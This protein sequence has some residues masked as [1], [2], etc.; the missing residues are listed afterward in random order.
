MPISPF[1]ADLIGFAGSFCIVAAFAYSNLS[2]NMNMILF[3][4]VNLTGAL[5]LIISLTVNY[6]L[7]TMV[8]E[9]VWVGI[10]LFGLVR[11]LSRRLKATG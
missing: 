2:K 9:I 4:L 6:N 8:L 5:L 7:P 10:A 3:N 11:E 1:A